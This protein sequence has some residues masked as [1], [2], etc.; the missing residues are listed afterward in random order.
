MDSIS[1]ISQIFITDNKTFK[2]E[3]SVIIDKNIKKEMRILFMV[4]SIY[5]ADL[6][7][8]KATRQKKI[9]TIKK[10]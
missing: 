6:Y 2:N 3:R 1:K 4:Y 9:V 7:I 5:Y 10:I 8:Q